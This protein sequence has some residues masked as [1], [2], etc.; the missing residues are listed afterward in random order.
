MDE[1]NGGIGERKD[2][3]WVWTADFDRIGVK[4][5]LLREKSHA[6]VK[7]FNANKLYALL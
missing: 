5:P 3:R 2:G 7:T 4:I 6:Q 1:M